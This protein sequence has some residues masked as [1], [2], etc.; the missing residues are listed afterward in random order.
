MF[1][2][3]GAKSIQVGIKRETEQE[4]EPEYG[5]SWDQGPPCREVTV[6]W[7]PRLPAD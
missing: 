5:P 1:K 7:S 3:Q 4:K 2:S 6:T